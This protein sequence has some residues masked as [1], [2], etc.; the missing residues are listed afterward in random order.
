MMAP[1][2]HSQA[3]TSVCCAIASPFYFKPT[4][5]PAHPATLNRKEIISLFIQSEL[6]A[7]KRQKWR[8][9]LRRFVLPLSAPM[10]SA[11]S[12]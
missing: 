12:G 5:Q 4:A 10:A 11:P 3:N 9:P 8:S 1:K 7:K 6:Y 2:T